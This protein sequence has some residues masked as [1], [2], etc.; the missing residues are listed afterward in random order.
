MKKSILWVAILCIL[1]GTVSF[2]I[3]RVN[4][5]YPD[6]KAKVYGINEKVELN[7][8]NAIVNGYKI[9][10]LEDFLSEYKVENKIND[11]SEDK[12][13]VLV[14][15]CTLEITGD[16]KGFPYADIKISSGAFKQGMSGDYI[17]A[18]ND[19]N[20]ISKVE[21]GSN[22]NIEIPFLIHSISF[23][24]EISV[25]KLN[26]EDWRLYF[27]VTPGRYVKLGK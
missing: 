24:K 4:K 1:L 9:M 3:V 11:S 12:I 6:D 22:V 8:Y 26:K 7:G 14:A 5:M 16:I 13:F 2:F 10:S 23:P 19:S 18:V 25:D 21:K 15:N 27:S 20:V 17:K